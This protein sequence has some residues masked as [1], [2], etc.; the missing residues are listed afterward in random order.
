[1][2]IGLLGGVDLL[3][4]LLITAALMLGVYAIVGPAARLGW[5]APRTLIA[6]ALAAALLAAFVLRQATAR[7]PL[8]NLR[9]LRV[10]NVAAA[11]VIQL[12][13][14]AGMSGCSFSAPST[15]SGSSGTTRS[16]SA[17]R[18]CPSRCSWP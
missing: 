14:V 15:C 16:R 1:M 4:G 13:S 3:G 10:P 5:G 12:L 8:L 6:A 17:S 9:L 7:T 11:N 2:G 18:S